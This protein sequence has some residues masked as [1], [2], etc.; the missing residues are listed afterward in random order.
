M[1][2]KMSKE[3]ILNKIESVKD[4]FKELKEEYNIYEEQTGRLKK[5]SYFAIQ[6]KLEEVIEYSIKIKHKQS[7]QKQTA[8]GQQTTS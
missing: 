6:K 3:K 5:T 4:I 2:F 1:N 7:G 8:N